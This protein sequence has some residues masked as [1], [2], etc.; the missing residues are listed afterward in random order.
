MNAGDLLLQLDDAET[1]AAVVL[2]KAGLD[3]ARARTAQLNH[4]TRPMARES[5][6]QADANLELARLGYERRRALLRQ[7]SG[8]TA[9]LEESKRALDVAQSQHAARATDEDRP[10]LVSPPRSDSV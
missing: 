10:I 8:T 4:V 5:H 3:L 6:R 9:Q 1:R 2:A 7:G